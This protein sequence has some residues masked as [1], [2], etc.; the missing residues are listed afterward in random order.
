MWGDLIR[1]ARC[2]RDVA[3]APGLRFS[4]LEIFAQCELQPIPPRIFSALSALPLAFIP[5]ILHRGPVRMSWRET[6][7]RNTCGGAAGATDSG[8]LASL[9]CL[10]RS[11]PAGLAAVRTYCVSLAIRAIA[12]SRAR[13]DLAGAD[14]GGADLREFSLSPHLRRRLS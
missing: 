14:H 13:R 8:R 3:A 1:I 2:R 7:G 10:A 4:P 12:N 6:D 9:C 5:R 11:R